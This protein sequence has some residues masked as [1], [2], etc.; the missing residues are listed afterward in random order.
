MES[1]QNYYIVCGLLAYLPLLL[2][3]NW[4][5]ESIDMRWKLTGRATED[6]T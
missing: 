2:R 1:C 5:E 4:A 6:V 3:C